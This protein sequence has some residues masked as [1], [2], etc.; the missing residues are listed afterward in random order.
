MHII[1][2]IFIDVNDE[3]SSENCQPE[4]QMDSENFGDINAYDDAILTEDEGN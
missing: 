1:S 2:H 4:I 3:S